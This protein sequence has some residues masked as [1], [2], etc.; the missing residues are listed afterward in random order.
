MG[1]ESGRS[2]SGDEDDDEELEELEETSR[3]HNTV[4]AFDLLIFAFVFVFALGFPWK[5]RR[6]LARV[7]CFG[8]VF[9][10]IKREPL[11]DR[12]YAT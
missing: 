1:M 9:T 4:A 5:S 10:P 6:K 7:M 12:C 3:L 11:S 2:S 8:F